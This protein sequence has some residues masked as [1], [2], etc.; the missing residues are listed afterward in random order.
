MSN[1]ATPTLKALAERLLAYEAAAGTPPGGKSPGEENSAL[2]RVCDTLRQP[3]ARLL[4]IAGFRALFSRALALAG[5][6]VSWLRALH[7][8]ADGTLEGLAELEAKLPADEIARGELALM[9]RV[10]ELL[11]T[12][13]GPALTLRLIQEVW[14]K[15]DFND[16]N[17]YNENKI[18]PSGRH[19]L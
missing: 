9:T 6:E 5:R 18:S 15:A 2:F 8:K 14:P 10:L 3:L 1:H 17:F 16:L 4:G 13:I 11:V 12:F 7:I 19:V